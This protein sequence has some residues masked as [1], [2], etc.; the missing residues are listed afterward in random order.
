MV[1][2]QMNREFEEGEIVGVEASVKGE[3]VDV[4]AFVVDLRVLVMIVR[5]LVVRN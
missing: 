4:E 5:R 1:L 2:N 3:I